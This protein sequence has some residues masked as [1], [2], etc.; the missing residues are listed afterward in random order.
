MTD[1]PLE[2][3]ATGSAGGDI[4][5]DILV[6]IIRIA[7]K[8]T[9]SMGGQDYSG[10]DYHGL[11]VR[12]RIEEG[13]EGIGEVFLTP[14][15]YGP[16][17][18]A[19]M[20]FLIKKVFAPAFIGQSVFGLNK[21]SH[22]MDKLWAMGNLWA[23]AALELALYD[24]A[25]KARGQSLVDLIGGK[26][27][28]SFPLVGGIGTDSAEGMAASAK[29]YVERGF[30]TIKLKIGEPG[31]LALDVDRVRAVRETVGEDIVIRADANSVFDADVPAAIKLAR[32]LEPY[33]LDHLEQ[34]L[35][36]WHI[37]G[38]ARVRDAVDTPIMADESVHSLQDAQRVIEA[39]AADVIKL[40]IAKNGGYRRCQEIIALCAA[41][42]V[43]VELGNGINSS[44][45]SLHEL[46]LACANPWVCPA[47]EFPGPD[48][49]VS[50]VLL[51]P[52]QIVD[53]EA[54]LP[55]GPGI[56]SE[57]DYDAF[58]DCRVDPKVFGAV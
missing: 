27:R 39:G 24:A 38:M 53:G 12:V 1:T 47:G 40:K 21:F 49:L 22:Q 44:A 41:A 58:N 17:T 8:K 26:V 32:A 11:L 28:D 14:G 7:P 54:I 52:M 3:S 37:E 43:R 16:D 46:M 42:G 4:I 56:G 33:N 57:L 13:V 48:K 50:D 19:G 18:P 23:K 55:A 20:M 51:N 25:A 29:E 2:G 35:V 10:M 34:P 9:Y 5:T 31:N 30:R 15:W 6:D 36:G 45:A